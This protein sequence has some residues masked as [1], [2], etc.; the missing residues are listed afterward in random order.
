MSNSRH[1]LPPVLWAARQPGRQPHAA[2][3]LQKSQ[4]SAVRLVDPVHGDRAGHDRLTVR[5]ARHLARALALEVVPREPPLHRGGN[6]LL[7][8]GP[9]EQ[10]AELGSPGLQH[11]RSHH[12]YLPVELLLVDDAEGTYDFHPMDIADTERL[13]AELYDVQRR[14][15]P[16]HV[17]LPPVPGM[18]VGLGED[19]VVEGLQPVE[20]LQLR[21]ARVAPPD[22]VQ[23]LSECDL[24][25]AQL[26]L[27]DLHCK[28]ESEWAIPQFHVVPD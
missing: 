17:Q 26:A 1:H 19:P 16:P 18:A 5:V 27:R 28:V 15:V 20:G 4:P 3:I 2:G 21:G 22:G 24:A 11:L 13:A 8:P 9:E 10:G 25:P 23:S 14:A 12:E 7:Q 6:P